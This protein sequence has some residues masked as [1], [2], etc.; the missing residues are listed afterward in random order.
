MML[1]MNVCRTF[2]S[3]STVA[4]FVVGVAPTPPK[5][6]RIFRPARCVVLMRAVSTSVSADAMLPSIF[7]QTTA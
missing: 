2:G 4:K 7:G 3:E 5:E 6:R 1:S